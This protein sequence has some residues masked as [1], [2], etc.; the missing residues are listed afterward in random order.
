MDYD[1]ANDG[2]RRFAQGGITA[3]IAINSG[4]L[5]ATLT[6]LDKLAGVVN[7][8]AAQFAL[9]AWALGVT[10][11]AF[12]WL[13]AT[14]SA[15]AFAN[16]RRKAEVASFWIAALMILTAIISFGLGAW[17]LSEGIDF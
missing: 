4:A 5:I 17:K 13:F 14:L 7:V 15:S 10:L 2:I 16:H 6:Q 1:N 11:G 9:K 3:S 8:D 12:S